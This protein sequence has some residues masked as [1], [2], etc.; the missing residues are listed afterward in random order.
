MRTRSAERG[1][2]RRPWTPLFSFS[3]S[4]SWGFRS[5]TFPLPWA[6][7]LHLFKIAILFGAYFYGPVGGGIAGAAVSFAGDLI[8]SN[9]YIIVG[10]VVLWTATG[11]LARHGLHPLFA[12]WSA[13]L[14]QLPWLILADYCFMGLSATLIRN[15]IIPLF[16]SDTL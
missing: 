1:F 13:F 8:L 15:L 11:Y 12:M 5:S 9:P 4:F 3:S 14:I 16:L 10:N 2:G 6:L 7:P